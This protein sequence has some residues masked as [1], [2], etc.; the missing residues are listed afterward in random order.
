MKKIILYFIINSVCT[1]LTIGQVSFED[2]S[3]RNIYAI[4]DEL[5][6]EKIISLNSSNKPYT[7]DKIYKLLKKA[8]KNKNL[9]NQL[10]R[11]EINIYLKNYEFFFNKDVDKNIKLNRKKFEFSY[12]KKNSFF[13]LKPI[14]GINYKTKKNET[15]EHYYGGLSSEAQVNK[16]WFFYAN[17]RDNTLSEPIAMPSYYRQEIGGNYKLWRENDFS[18]MQGGVIHSF[19]SG[20]IALIKEHIQWGDNYFGSNIF[21]G[22][23]PSF[24]MIKLY[25]KITDRVELNYLH[26]WLISEVVDSSR[27]YISSAGYLRGIYRQKNLAANLISVKFYNNTYF[28]F[29]NSIIYSDLGGIHP[30]YLIPF[31]FYKSVDHTLN[32]NIENQN[33]QIF[34]N[35]SCREIKHCHIYSSLFID[36]FKKSRV[37]TDSL[38]NFLSLKIGTKVSNWPIPNISNILEINYSSPMTYQH[39]VEGT[40]FESNQYNLGHYMRDNSKTINYQLSYKLPKRINLIFDYLYAMHGDDI[41]YSFLNEFDPTS[42]PIRQNKTWD[43]ESYQFSITKEF[44]DNIYL[45]LIYEITNSKGYDTENYS[46]EYYLNKFTPEFYRGKNKILSMNLNIGF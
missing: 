1:T 11:K 33:S 13:I 16:N 3:N 45:S 32:H 10:L 6:N 30:A 23:T 35:F 44:K 5:A 24:P 8:K 41:E 17:L 22:R 38:N 26:A 15:F 25:V 20:H 12:K 21:S 46:A 7:R 18:E 4:L 43:F 29:G 34:L 27:S 31:L 14:W 2:F 42:I 19:K 37:F 28:S 40:T 36:E 9:K 39:Y